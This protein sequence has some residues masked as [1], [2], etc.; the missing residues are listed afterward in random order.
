MDNTQLQYIKI[1]SQYADKLEQFEAC[2]VKA[3]KEAH[4]L[5]DTAEKKCEQ[6]RAALESGDM[7]VMWHTIQQYI[8]RYGQDWSRFQG[9]QLQRIDAYTLAQLSA[10]D[11]IRQLHCIII[12]VYEDTGLKSASKE[13]FQKCTKRLLKQSKMFTDKE[14]NAMFV[15]W[16]RLK[17]I[18]HYQI[19]GIVHRHCSQRCIEPQCY[20]YGDFRL[21]RT[22]LLMNMIT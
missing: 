9:V 5:A 4:S 2:I 16:Y 17:A 7:D 3:A 11:L 19:M 22:H 1:Q 13:A 20:S 8:S 12:L 14:P 10:A 15:Y 18:S 6:A 21:K